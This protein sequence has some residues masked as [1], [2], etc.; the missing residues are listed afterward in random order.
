MS[1]SAVYK[2]RLHVTVKNN[3][4]LSSIIDLHILPFSLSICLSTVFL[5]KVSCNLFTEKKNP[6]LTCTSLDFS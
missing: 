5:K 6:K 4:K 2:R 1:F 3:N